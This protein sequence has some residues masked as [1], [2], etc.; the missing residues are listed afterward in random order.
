[1]AGGWRWSWVADSGIQDAVTPINANDGIPDNIN[2][3]DK[4]EELAT[5]GGTDRPP[6]AIDKFYNAAD[7]LALQQDLQ[8]ILTNLQSCVIP[9]TGDPPL[10]DQTVVEIG[11]V[12]ITKVTDCANEDGWV[13]VEAA[14]PYTEIE[15]C[16]AACDQLTS[17]G[18]AEVQFFCNAG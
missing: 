10:P 15:L 4:L 2:P 7:E 8:D 13:Y 11:G 12:E 16:N 5:D 14:P 18:S 6:P 1:M 17:F 9:L 3:Y